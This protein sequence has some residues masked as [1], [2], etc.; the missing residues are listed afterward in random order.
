MWTTW[1]LLCDGARMPPNPPLHWIG[2]F[3]TG[4]PT[5]GSCSL[6]LL[7][8]PDMALMT[9]SVLL[10]VAQL[11]CQAWIICMPCIYCN[12]SVPTLACKASPRGPMALIWSSSGNMIWRFVTPF[13][14]GDRVNITLFHMCACSNGEVSATQ[15]LRTSCEDLKDV[16]VHIKSVIKAECQA[17]AARKKK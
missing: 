12:T 9:Y 5:S 13:P 17:A 14:T 10:C 6:T 3:Y 4:T 2:S 8:D 7:P 15:V 16:C 11:A 1:H